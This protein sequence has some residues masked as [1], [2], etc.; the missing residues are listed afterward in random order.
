MIFWHL[1]D[2]AEG[3]LGVFFVAKKDG[4]LR[5][6]FDTRVANTYFKTP[7]PLVSRRPA[8]SAVSSVLPV[9]ILS[10]LVIL[11][12]LFMVFNCPRGFLSF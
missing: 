1:Y 9:L 2:G 4:R 6:I 12:V 7:P 5:L 10:V 11:S 8:P 3:L